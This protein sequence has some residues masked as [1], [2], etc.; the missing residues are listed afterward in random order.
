[1]SKIIAP[2]KQYSGISAGVTFV[3][4]VGETY[5]SNLI[6]WFESHGYEIEKKTQGEEATTS[7]IKKITEDSEDRPKSVKNTS[8]K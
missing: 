4:G 2:N 3:N 8:K 5:D 7:G 6:A 1:M